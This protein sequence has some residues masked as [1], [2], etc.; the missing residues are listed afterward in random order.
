[1]WDL[2]FK[3]ILNVAES[4]FSTAKHLHDVL[5]GQ[6]DT[7]GHEWTVPTIWPPAESWFCFRH[8][9]WS[10]TW[11]RRAAA[12]ICL[13]KCFCLCFCCT[14]RAKPEPKIPCEQAHSRRRSLNQFLPTLLAGGGGG[15]EDGNKHKGKQEGTMGLVFRQK[16]LK[17]HFVHYYIQI[18][19]YYYSLLTTITQ[20]YNEYILKSN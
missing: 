2:F 4:K 15:S 5:E 6:K 18:V 3:N 16:T 8:S 13:L 12:G 20:Q 19:S 10:T 9:F 11:M 7:Q 17:Y 14:F 1:M